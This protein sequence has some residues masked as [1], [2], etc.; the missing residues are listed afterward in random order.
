M[1]RR[2]KRERG[3]VGACVGFK[4]TTPLA[5]KKGNFPASTKWFRLLRKPERGYSISQIQDCFE[6]LHDGKGSFT[7]L[8]AKREVAKIIEESFW[9]RWS[10]FH[11]A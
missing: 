4:Q 6:I 2:T 5:A 11:Q 3:A 8:E 10:N 1:G 9:R 7:Y